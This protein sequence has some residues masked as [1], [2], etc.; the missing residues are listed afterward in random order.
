MGRLLLGILGL[1]AALIVIFLV[2]AVI[3]VIFFYGIFIALVV[4]AAF[5]MFKIG[6]WSGRRRDRRA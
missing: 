4:V 1:V 2:L 6:R 5:L 3:H